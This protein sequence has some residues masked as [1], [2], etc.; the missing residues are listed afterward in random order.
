MHHEIKAKA[1]VHSR[2]GALGA[3]MAA[4]SARSQEILDPVVN[5]AFL[6][7]ALWRFPT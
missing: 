4:V 2:D 5:V 1:L 6:R 3:Q 7:A